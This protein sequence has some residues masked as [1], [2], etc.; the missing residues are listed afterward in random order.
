MFMRL[1]R[2]GGQGNDR[3]GDPAHARLVEIDSADHD[4]AD[5]GWDWQTLMRLIGDQARIDAA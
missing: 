3:F 5:T 4:L 1:Y 2:V